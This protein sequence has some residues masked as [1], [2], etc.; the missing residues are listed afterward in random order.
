MEEYD[1]G[2]E[3]L[4]YAFDRGVNDKNAVELLA[5]AYNNKAYSYYETGKNIKE[6]LK[7][8]DKAIALNPN[9]GLILSTKAELLYKAK[10]FKE[11]YQY[12][13]KAME[14]EPDEPGIKKDLEIMEAAIQ[15]RPLK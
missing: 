11:A 15:K 9:N 4:E 3:R 14:L 6:G 8:I 2:I 1:K 13:Q 10:K 5:A 7:T 12:I